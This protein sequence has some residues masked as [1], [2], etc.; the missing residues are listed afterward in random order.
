MKEDYNNIVVSTLNELNYLEEER[1]RDA[2]EVEMRTELE[3]EVKA[4]KGSLD[5]SQYD[6]YLKI[7]ET[8]NKYLKYQIEKNATNSFKAGLRIGLNLK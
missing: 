8:Y 4:F 6:T 3:R 1:K 2:K 7:V 5:Y